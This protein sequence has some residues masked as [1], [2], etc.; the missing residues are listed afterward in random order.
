MTESFWNPSVADEGFV[1]IAV[2]NL[3][4]G[5]PSDL[6]SE[7]LLYVLPDRRLR[8]ARFRN[9]MDLQRSLIGDLVARV[10]VC[11]KTACRNTSLIFSVNEYGKPFFSG[12][13]ASHFNISH[14][15]RWVAFAISDSPIGIDVEEGLFYD[16][17]LA[18]NYFTS[19]EQAY[20]FSRDEGRR[21]RFYEIWTLK[22]S[23]I[24]QL[25][26]GLST[27]LDSFYVKK[28][29]NGLW[30]INGKGVA[31]LCF[32]QKWLKDDSVL[33]ACFYPKRDI[34]FCEIKMD[35]LVEKVRNLDKISE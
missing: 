4:G 19:D 6:V 23:F 35:E 29:D 30:R 5:L 3:N 14:S 9:S 33:A 16:E 28:A 32:Y 7:M 1:E 2:V 17:E 15:G 10:F 21:E 31:E 25:G 13:Y 24:K 22:E 11:E 26:T 8:L 12:A 27:P 18:I 34:E 20:V